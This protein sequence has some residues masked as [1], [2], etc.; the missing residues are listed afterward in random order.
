MINF[1]SI[2]WER[3]MCLKHHKH[4]QNEASMLT[5]C[6]YPVSALAYTTKLIELALNLYVTMYHVTSHNTNLSCQLQ[7][8]VYD[9]CN[10]S[11]LVSSSGGSVKNCNSK[12]RFR[13]SNIDLQ[14]YKLIGL[15]FKL[16]LTL[17]TLNTLMMNLFKIDLNLFV[18][19]VRV[20]VDVVS[21]K[22]IILQPYVGWIRLKTF[23]P[24]NFSRLYFSQL[25]KIILLSETS[26]SESTYIYLFEFSNNDNRST[27]RSSVIFCWIWTCKCCM[28]HFIA[29]IWF[30]LC[31]SKSDLEA[32]LHLRWSSL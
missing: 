14:L 23:S 31:L 26:L 30:Y 8:L 29:L 28:E 1:K 5:T 7:L 32:L 4:L 20:Q 18:K 15:Y 6:W 2:Y 25:L 19:I 22:F 17:I 12:E 9:K 3:E 24:T 11:R 27:H 21:W 13:A 10:Y 16:K